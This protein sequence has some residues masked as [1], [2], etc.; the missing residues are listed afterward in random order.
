MKKL[1]ISLLILAFTFSCKEK[2]EKVDNT[3][4]VNAQLFYNGNIITM[5]SEEPE[6]VEAV[7]EQD[8]KIVFVGS[9]KDAEENF[10]NAK[11]IDLNG[12]TMLPGFIDPH[13]HFGMV[14]SSMGQVDLNSQPVGDITS[15]EDMMQKMKNYKSENNIPEGEWIFGWGYDESQIKEKRHPNK[16]EIDAV[17][18]NNPVY[19]QHTSGHMGVGNSMALEKMNVTT[20]SKDPDG[21][22][23]ER[24]PNSKE[25]TGLVQETAMYAFV[26]NMM[27][28]LEK[29]QSEFFDVTQNYYASNGITTAH[30]GM[31]DR[32]TIQFFQT[33]A[34]AGKF[35]ID[36]L[37]LG[38][39]AEL[40][41]N[42]K[43][44]LINWKIYKNRFKVQG[45]KIIADGS[46]QGKTAFFSEAFLTPVPGCESDCKGLPS[47]SQKNMNALFVMAYK[48]DNQLFIHGNGDGAIDMILEA[49]KFACEQL[50][51]P[52]DKDRRTVVIHSQFVRA[53][54]M[55][56]YVKYNILPSFFTNH[57]YFWGDVHVE[58]LGEE[59][60]FFL[61]PI[62]SAEKLNLKYTNHSDATVTPINPLFTIW[63]AVN[64]VSR[65]G[66]IIGPGERATPYQAL[67]AITTHA[68]FEYFE[69]KSKGSLSKG[70]VAD[71]VILDKNPLSVDPM[72]IRDIK[73]VET[74]KDG[75]SIFKI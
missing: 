4:E 1:L 23:I 71:F 32:N 6:Y 44:S 60:A 54:Q 43:D 46:P 63:S 58:N 66:K 31:T 65:T 12:N 25:P 50:N 16:N 27:K 57:A 67:K 15:I 75:K 64:R 29:K 68:A 22:T 17:L 39:Y 36:L 28:I 2:D 41:T 52:L 20:D 70:K 30:D 59:R 42:L 35:K 19:L 62:A 48:D 7:V 33:Q 14:S 37:A 56:T 55:D 45:T 49:H 11:R 26:G 51:Q 24:F 40:E 74:I 10:A 9:K 73:V 21:G 34:D 72:E 69:E 61:S 47:I 8:G 5:D 38:G 53:D 3:S 18:P 13:S